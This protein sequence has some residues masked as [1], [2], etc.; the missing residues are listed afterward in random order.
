MTVSRPLLLLALC[1]TLLPACSKPTVETYRVAKDTPPADAAKSPGAPTTPAPAAPVAPAPA[2]GMPPAATTGGNAMANTAVATASG[3]DL[4]WTPPAHWNS[5][6]GSAMRKATYTM[7]ADGVAGEA[8]LA[9]TAFPGN[10]GGD[11]ANL[12]RWRGQVELPPVSESQFESSVTRLE[13]NGLKI[14]I[15]DI[16]GKAQGAP[17]RILGAMIPHHG[18]TWFV[19]LMGPDAIVVKEKAAF[20]AFIDTVKAAPA[21]K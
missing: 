21:A 11:L 14:I 16:P 13:R 10:V 15:A 7:K 8:E 20:A 6:S 2:P 19:K 17:T 9:I 1:A 5:K 3:A 12:N 4:V 18:S